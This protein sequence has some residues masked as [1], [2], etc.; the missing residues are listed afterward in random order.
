MGDQVISK[1]T[2]LLGAG[3]DQAI[4]GPST[5]DITELLLNKNTDWDIQ[6]DFE[7]PE[8]LLK[9]SGEFF[10]KMRR[11]NE[12]K[13]YNQ[14]AD[15]ST[16][17]EDFVYILETLSNYLNPQASSSK[18]GQLPLDKKVLKCK[19]NFSDW[20]WS[21]IETTYLPFCI[22][23]IRQRILKFLDQL[24]PAGNHSWYRNFWQENISENPKTDIL[25]LNYGNTIQRCLNKKLED[26]FEET[27]ED[28]LSF[29]PRKIPNE[30]AVNI[31]HL[32][33]SVYWGYP[34]LRHPS[35][36]PDQ[37]PPLRKMTSPGQENNWVFSN[38]IKTNTGRGVFQ[39]SITTGY[40][41][42]EKIHSNPYKTYFHIAPKILRKSQRLVIIGY[43]FWD[44]HVNELIEYFFE[45]HSENDKTIIVTYEKNS[46]ED[47]KKEEW[48]RD[49]E[50]PIKV[51]DLKNWVS[52]ENKWLAEFLSQKSDKLPMEFKLTENKNLL[53][54]SGFIK[55]QLHGF[56][57]N[58]SLY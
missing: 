42:R 9:N 31:F 43:G 27:K 54:K 55:I 2:F 28:F 34:S 6:E 14:Y 21:K 18:K 56:D 3:A 4:D 22:H 26:G 53:S 40:L 46:V 23:L 38:L 15:A 11:L 12:I 51:R 36:D 29:N 58:F 33:G 35:I 7:I 16:N 24:E 5:T 41:K 10:E 57:E 13:P 25:T 32:H 47:L 44:Y 49:C 17:F 39:N 52:V 45:T 37:N 48:Q 8:G 50:Y 1:Q 30:D 19:E 20:D